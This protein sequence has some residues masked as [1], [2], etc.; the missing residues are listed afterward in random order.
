MRRPESTACSRPSR[1]IAWC[2]A[3]G[4]PRT[5]TRKDTPSGVTSSTATPRTGGS[6]ARRAHRRRVAFERGD[7]GDRD[8][9]LG[10]LGSAAR[11][12]DARVPLRRERRPG[13]QLAGRAAVCAGG[14]ERPVH[15]EASRSRL[16]RP[17][18][19]HAISAVATGGIAQRIVVPGPRLLHGAHQVVAGVR[20]DDRQAAAL[21]VSRRRVIFSALVSLED[22]SARRPPPRS[23]ASQTSVT[24]RSLSQNARP[25]ASTASSIAVPSKLTDSMLPGARRKLLT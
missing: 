8:D 10:A 21:G 22:T 13:L 11:R 12:V 20:P 15:L 25:E 23:S 2:S 3:P 9:L 5:L 24:G 1:W 7:A 4:S 14:R 16:A 17:P 19:Q 6:F 18:H